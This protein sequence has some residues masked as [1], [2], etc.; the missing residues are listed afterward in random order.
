[1]ERRESALIVAVPEA[2]PL[3]GE[4]RLRYDPVAAHGVP[5]HITVLFPFL[6]PERLDEA[7]LA[8]LTEQFV[9]F[10]RFDY[11][12][13][14]VGRFDEGLVYLVPEPGPAFS[15]LTD[16]VVARFGV[17]PYGG[18]IA[19]PIPHLTVARDA[20]VAVLDAVA[21]AVAAGLPILATAG[22]VALIVRDES[23]RWRHVRRFPLA[24]A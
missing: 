20:P 12:L 11:T 10:N 13:T 3:V 9:A 6:P 19:D 5:A 7:V 18:E 16:A 4:W 8:G 23:G 22:H 24:E 1:M 21:S 15:R 14:S 17:P 2:E